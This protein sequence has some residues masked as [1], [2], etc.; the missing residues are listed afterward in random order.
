MR[1]LP[2]HRCRSEAGADRAPA[3]D[4]ISSEAVVSFSAHHVLVPGRKQ[5]W[6]AECAPLKPQCPVAWIRAL[7][8][9]EAAAAPVRRKQ[10]RAIRPRRSTPGCP[11][12]LKPESASG[13]GASAEPPNLKGAAR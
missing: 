7:R 1:L 12:A 3:H 10:Q 6:F 11:V 8:V 2:F 13:P 9:H 4:W 5:Q